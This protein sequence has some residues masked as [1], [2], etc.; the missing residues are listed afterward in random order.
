MDMSASLPESITVQVPGGQKATA[1]Y[2]GVGFSNI[3]IETDRILFSTENSLAWDEI[4]KR[5]KAKQDAGELTDHPLLSTAMPRREGISINNVLINNLSV[6]AKTAL[7]NFTAIFV[8]EVINLT[9][10]FNS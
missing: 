5:A 10:D 6:E 4:E 9:G 7:E 3:K 1:T 8:S 2:H